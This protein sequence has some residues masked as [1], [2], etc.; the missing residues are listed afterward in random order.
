MI[1]TIKLVGIPISPRG[2]SCALAITPYYF[3]PF[4]SYLLP[5]STH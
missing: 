1:I 3:V 2:S 4:A 5:H